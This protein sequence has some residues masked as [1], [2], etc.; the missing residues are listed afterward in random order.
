MPDQSVKLDIRH[1]LRLNVGFLLHRDV[2]FNR[3]FDFDGLGVRVSDDLE[4]RNLRGWLRF[5]RTAQGLYG[6][7]NLKATGYVGHAKRTWTFGARLR[8][9]VIRDEDAIDAEGVWGWIRD[10]LRDLYER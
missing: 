9:V 6:Q 10:R 7:G 2:G 5:T 4:V 8:I 3:N 1:P